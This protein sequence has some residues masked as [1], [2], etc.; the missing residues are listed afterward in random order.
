MKAAI[1]DSDRYLVEALPV[2]VEPNPS[3]L[4][5]DTTP[6]DREIRVRHQR[7]KRPGSIPL[8]ICGWRRQTA[9]TGCRRGRPTVLPEPIS[10]PRRVY[11]RSFRLSHAANTICSRWRWYAASASADGRLPPIDAGTHTREGADIVV[12]PLLVSYWENQWTTAIEVKSWVTSD[13][14]H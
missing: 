11:R 8:G 12:N 7:A 6:L 5:V 9:G 10:E 14:G 3:D 2:P 13:R 1:S 4:A